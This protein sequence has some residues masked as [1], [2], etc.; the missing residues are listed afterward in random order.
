VAFNFSSVEASHELRRGRHGTRPGGL[1]PEPRNTS[2]NR[3]EYLICRLTLRNLTT[4]RMNIL[5]RCNLPV[6]AA[7][8]GPEPRTPVPWRAGAAQPAAPCARGPDPDADAPQR[9]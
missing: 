8:R 2:E 3:D 7:A 6:A 9:R 4:M 5:P 1:S